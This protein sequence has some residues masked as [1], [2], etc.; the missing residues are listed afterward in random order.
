MGAPRDTYKYH[1]KRGNQK[2]LDT[3]EKSE[4]DRKDPCF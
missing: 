3:L 4:S 1:F 2:H